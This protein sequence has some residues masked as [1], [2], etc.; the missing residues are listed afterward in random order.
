MPIG[1]GPRWSTQAGSFGCTGAA[2]D[3]PPMSATSGQR[4]QQSPQIHR[5][6]S[7]ET[8]SRPAEGRD[9]KSRPLPWCLRHFKPRFSGGFFASL[10]T[11]F[12]GLKPTRRT[13]CFEVPSRFRT[14]FSVTAK[15][16]IPPTTAD[17]E[18]GRTR[19]EVALKVRAVTGSFA[20]H[21]LGIYQWGTEIHA[22]TI[23]DRVV[24]ASCR[25]TRVYGPSGPAF[26]GDDGPS[27]ALDPQTANIPYVGWAGNQIRIAKCLGQQEMRDSL[28]LSTESTQRLLTPVWVSG[29]RGRS[30]TGAASMR[31]TPV[32]LS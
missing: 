4:H 8:N 21:P 9:A 28:S 10:G 29:L 20:T 25:S 11:A 31:T 23:Q 6:Q 19:G 3:T 27:T 16:V 15:M 17:P 1:R 32:R 14:K 12:P 2:S 5:P 24:C 22:Q 30:R 7:V 13:P 18:G 26:A